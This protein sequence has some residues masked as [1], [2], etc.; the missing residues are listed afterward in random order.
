MQQQPRPAPLLDSEEGALQPPASP[1]TRFDL[2]V[3]ALAGE[4]WPSLPD[5]PGRVH[6]LQGDPEDAEDTLAAAPVCQAPKR[7][8]RQAQLQNLKARILRVRAPGGR[9]WLE[10]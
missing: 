6:M 4:P 3:S 1:A 8:K 10:P 7:S 2:L 5:L 9:G